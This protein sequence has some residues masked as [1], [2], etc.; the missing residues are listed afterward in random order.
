MSAALVDPQQFL[1]RFGLTEFRA[2]QRAV[3]DAV[4][5]GRDCLC[6]MPTGGGKSLCYQ[7]P[8]IARP[9]VTFVVSPLIALMKDQVDSMQRQGIAAT[10]INSSLT[11]N[12]QYERL[13]EIQAGKFDLV[14]VA[15]E[16]LRNE[17]F[18]EA[19][20][21]I[22]IQMLAIDEAHCI[23]QWGH[24][25][26]PDYQRLGRFRK[27][28][29]NPQTIALTATA[30]QLVQ[31]DISKCL[32]LRD[33]ATFVSGFARSNL[34]LFVETPHGQAGKDQRMLEF[35]EKTPGCGIIYAATRK[36]CEKIVELLQKN[37][38]RP[39]GFYH[40]G[41]DQVQRRLIQ[42]QFMSGEI[43]IIIATNAFGMGVDKPDL[44]FV[45]HYQL[46]GS[47]EAYYQEVGRAGR[48]GRESRC[49]LLFSHQDRYI[50]EFFIENNYPSREV[51]RTVYQYLLGQPNDP[52]ELTLQEIKD[53]LGISIGTEGIA[54]CQKLLEQAGVLERLDTKQNLAS[55]RI[56]SDQPSLIEAVKREAKNART[57]LSLLEP[58][59]ADRR[60]ER[61][62]FSLGWLTDRSGLK[63]DAVTKA[64]RELDKLKFF[65]YVPPFRGRAIH[66][67]RR[68]L[69]FQELEIDFSDLE[70]RK[71]A[72]Y[73]RLERVVSYC[74][75]TRCRQVD[76][77]HYFG[78]H[79]QA[80]CGKC[81]HCRKASW[82]H[83]PVG[84]FDPQINKT[85]QGAETQQLTWAKPATQSTTDLPPPIHDSEL[86]TIQVALSGAART[87]GRIG[88]QL[89]NQML[90]GS[91][92]K[93]LTSLRLHRIKTFGALKWLKSKEVAVLL[94]ALL[95]AG[96][97]TQIELNMFRPTV[98]ITALGT[99]VMVG[100][101]PPP[102]VK[103]PLALSKK[104]QALA[105]IREP[106]RQQGSGPDEILADHK[107]S[108]RPTEESPSLP[109][110]T[111]SLELDEPQAP[112]LEHV[113]AP[114]NSRSSTP[115][116]ERL[117]DYYWTWRMF[118]EGF[119][120][121]ETAAIRRLSEAQVL[122]HLDHA[123][124]N[125]LLVNPNWRLPADSSIG[126]DSR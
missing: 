91:N 107:S 113:V 112:E 38:K 92:A 34:S 83:A 11:P 14:Y 44:R 110:E 16:R 123:S 61:V 59:V 106:Q 29:G 78:D 22:K 109:E 84:E 126:M 93:K 72:E 40:A 39:T 115:E 73:D 20:T 95:D 42:E 116:D 120:M 89:L 104:I 62:Y 51:V 56:D 117:P 5:S 21:S 108:P 102:R 71:K 30:T 43:P 76:I 96:L 24:D 33:P 13:R 60:Y 67:R 82:E 121:S 66:F 36:N 25:F 9:G 50:Q 49:L 18:L 1:H 77:L 2:G 124:H 63:L 87:Q 27:R 8:S 57:V 37:L 75:G 80:R 47:L 4:F 98:E 119:S 65:D 23:S 58:I 26:R 7:L 118:V 41:L 88:K 101:M 3:I 74:R 94:D 81:D 54:S 46:P 19:V 111:P 45:L 53:D 6:I 103:L 64:L 97:L 17:R 48:D 12:E 79:D 32:E 90:V 99:E 68:D 70:R 52:V 31:E 28:L 15:P 122:T 85:A 86:A 100:R 125:G 114:E 55:V 105:P 10:F 69:K 35:L